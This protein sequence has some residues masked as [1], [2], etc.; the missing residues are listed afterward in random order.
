MGFMYPYGYVADHSYGVD[1]QKD[2][3]SW[4]VNGV[5][6]H[7]ASQSSSGGHMDLNF[8]VQLQL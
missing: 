2:T 1:T 4:K 8:L 6:S 5:E 7:H 3:G